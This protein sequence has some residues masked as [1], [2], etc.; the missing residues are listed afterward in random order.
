[1]LKIFSTI[2]LVLAASLCQAVNIEMI[3]PGVWTALQ[4]D[5]RKFNDCNS[6]IVATDDLVIIVDA[7]ENQDDVQQIIQFADT[8]IGKPVRYLINTH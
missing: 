2:V 1:M 8:Q 3:S 4:P 5:S 6:L 7:Q